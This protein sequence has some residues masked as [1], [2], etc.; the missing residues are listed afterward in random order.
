MKDV[1]LATFDTDLTC[2]KIEKDNIKIFNIGQYK[3]R[4]VFSRLTQI[5]MF[6]R[7]DKQKERRLLNAS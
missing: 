5:V 1:F 7:S 2:R 4:K 6:D 3:V